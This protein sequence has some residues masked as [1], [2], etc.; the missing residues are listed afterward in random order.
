MQ[1]R[2]VQNEKTIQELITHLTWSINDLYKRTDCE[3]VIIRCHSWFGSNINVYSIKHKLNKLAEEFQ[4]EKF[5]EDAV[6]KII[7]KVAVILRILVTVIRPEY[8]IQAPIHRSGAIHSAAGKV[9]DAILI[10]C[11]EPEHRYHVRGRRHTTLR[12]SNSRSAM[13]QRM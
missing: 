13:H 8:V 2:D 11:P 12:H 3:K 9:N 7:H 10:R 5:A 6:C 1:H 4:T